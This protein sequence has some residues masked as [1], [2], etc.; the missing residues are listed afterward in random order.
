MPTITGTPFNDLLRGSNSKD[1]IFGLDGFAILEGGGGEDA[2]YGDSGNDRLFGG[3][4]NDR[5]LGGSGSNLI[6]GGAGSDYIGLDDSSRHI[7]DGGGAGDVVFGDG[8]NAF[9]DCGQGIDKTPATQLGNDTIY[10]TAR[11]DILYGVNGDGRR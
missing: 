3:S 4:H 5:L 8:F 9:G 10:G 6:C 7:F 1:T 2:L 11:D